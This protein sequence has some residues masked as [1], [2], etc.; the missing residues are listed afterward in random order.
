M[1]LFKYFSEALRSLLGNGLVIK[2]AVLFLPFL[3]REKLYQSVITYRIERLRGF[4]PT[5]T[6]VVEQAILA[7]REVFDRKL[8][9]KDKIIYA[10]LK[11]TA[12]LLT[13]DGDSTDPIAPLSIYQSETVNSTSFAAFFSATLQYLL[14]KNKLSDRYTCQQYL[15][16]RRQNGVNLSDRYR[17]PYGGSAFKSERDIVAIIDRKTGEKHFV[18]PTLFEQTSIVGIHVEGYDT[19]SVSKTSAQ[20]SEQ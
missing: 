15:A 17:S 8:D 1:D 18:D 20:I 2:L 16:Q 3:L 4:Q 14:V 9:S 7:H 12:D 5:L 13:F 11:I 19:P 10:A 6:P